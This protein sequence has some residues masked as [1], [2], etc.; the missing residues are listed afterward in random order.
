MIQRSNSLR[1]VL[2]PSESMMSLILLYSISKNLTNPACFAEIFL[3]NQLT[4]YDTSDINDIKRYGDI[5]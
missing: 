4:L 1:F 3:L 2:P 5:E